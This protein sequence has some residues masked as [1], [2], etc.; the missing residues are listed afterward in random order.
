MRI[1]LLWNQLWLITMYTEL[2]VL[3]FHTILRCQNY[4]LLVNFKDFYPQEASLIIAM[5]FKD[6]VTWEFHS[7][8]IFR[9]CFIDAWCMMMMMMMHDDDDNDDDHDDHDDDDHD[10]VSQVKIDWPT[11]Q[12]INTVSNLLFQLTLAQSAQCML[13]F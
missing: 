7:S 9:L 2:E 13:H 8:S 5:S 6:N 1:F 11:L 4:N 10:G 3:P 12:Y